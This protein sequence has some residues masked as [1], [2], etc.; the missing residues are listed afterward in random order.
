MIMTREA[1]MFGS[2]W[3]EG[4]NLDA[5]NPDRQGSGEQTV[6]EAL[7]VIGEQDLGNVGDFSLSRQEHLGEKCDKQTSTC[8][9]PANQRA[10]SSWTCK[11]PP[12]SCKSPYIQK[13]EYSKLQF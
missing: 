5:E 6:E 12:S 4:R 3:A 2:R 7:Y 13:F 8:G 10:W 9:S 1:E 11:T